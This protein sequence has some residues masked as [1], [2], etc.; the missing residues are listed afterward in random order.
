MK[1]TA[2]GNSSMIQ[3]AKWTFSTRR[4]RMDDAVALKSEVASA[5]SGDL[6]LARVQQ[7][8]SHERVQLRDGRP[9]TIFVDDLIV[10][11]C[12]ARYA[13]DQF[14][15]I[16]QIDPVATDLLAGGG[17]M[18][19]MRHCHD[20]MKRPTQVVPLGLLADAAHNTLNLERYA[21][22]S[23]ISPHGIHAIAVV[24]A[25]MNSGKTTSV[26]SLVHGFKRAGFRVAALKVTGTGSF[27]DYNAYVDAGANFVADFT[28]TGMVSTYM[29]PL[30]RIVQAIG[31]LMN[32][33]ANAG[34][35]VAVVEFADGL[36]QAETAALLQDPEV[37]AL[38]KG[39]LYAAPD[40]LAAL[41]GYQALAAVDI[42]PLALT[43]LISRSPLNIQEA[44]AATGLTV[45]TRE[46]LRDPA[47]A[48]SLRNYSMAR[49]ERRLVA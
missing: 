42:R 44:E 39:F 41:G 34:C 6:V 11:A 38:F 37:R 29:Q 2:F 21:M 8:G 4:V 3:A 27:G 47:Q 12:G 13:S 33:A 26:A 17:C 48:C 22:L 7:L 24:G 18:G 35:E 9:A 25:A 45:L 16:A 10:A 30:R 23:T 1:T 20:K 31:T 5:R 28:D 36:L 49:H 40:S 32:A 43:G 14:E 15:G 19:K 46:A